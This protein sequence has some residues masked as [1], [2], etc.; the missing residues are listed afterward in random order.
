MSF[1]AL[2][3]SPSAVSVSKAQDLEREQPIVEESET[4][5][6]DAY[7]DSKW[8]WFVAVSG[9]MNYLVIFGS[10]NAFGLF[11]EYYLNTMFVNESATAISWISTVSTLATLSIGIFGGPIV[12]KVGIRWATISAAIISTVGLLLASVSTKVWHLLLTQGLIFGA[13]G[14]IIIN[15]SLVMPSLWFRKHKNIAIAITSSGSGFGALVIGPIIQTTLEKYGIHW[16]FRILALVNIIGTGFSIVAFVPRPDF[17]PIRRVIDFHLLSRPLTI[18]LCI[19]GFFAEWAYVIPPFYFPA[20]VRAIGKS[21]S[22]SSQTILVFSAFSGVSRLSSGHLANR[23][24]PTKVLMIAMM[25]AGIACLAL[26]LPTKDFVLYYIFFAICGFF[27]PLFFPLC[28]VIVARSY[29]D[30]ELQMANGVIYFFY[31]LSTLIGIPITGV[32]LD[33]VG[34]RTSYTPV[35]ILAGILFLLSG[36]VLIFQYIYC[37]KRMPSLK[38]HRI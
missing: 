11:Q 23:F 12:A 14:S 7:Y 25:V 3:N 13:S 8:S 19:G 10:F 6:I 26:W 4:S 2:E 35:I 29:A 17:K 1:K 31:G 9:A 16:S 18:F 30:K 32:L 5:S 20:S 38:D 24:G 22:I 36:V 28:P 21:R 33:K 37:K 15:I 34:H 27:S